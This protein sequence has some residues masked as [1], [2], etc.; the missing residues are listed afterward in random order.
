MK[1]LWD[2]EFEVVNEE[3]TEIYR[4]LDEGYENILILF[5]ALSDGEEMSNRNHMVSLDPVSEDNFLDPRCIISITE[6]STYVI[7]Y[8][9]GGLTFSRSFRPSVIYDEGA[10]H[11]EVKKT[12]ATN[13]FLLTNSVETIPNHMECKTQVVTNNMIYLLFYD[14]QIAPYIQDLV[15][16]PEDDFPAI[17]LGLVIKNK[18]ITI[19]KI[20]RKHL[21]PKHPKPSVVS[22]PTLFD[23]EDDAEGSRGAST[24]SRRKLTAPKSVKLTQQTSAEFKVLYENGEVDFSDDGLKTKIS[25]GIKKINDDGLKSMHAQ[26]LPE[27][28]FYEL[29]DGS[30]KTL[31]DNNLEQY[32]LSWCTDEAA[33]RYE[34]F[35]TVRKEGDMSET[36]ERLFTTG[37]MIDFPIAVL[38]GGKHKYT[39]HKYSD[40]Q[41]SDPYVDKEFSAK[42]AVLSILYLVK[43][44]DKLSRTSGA[45]MSVVSPKHVRFDHKQ[46]PVI[47]EY[48]STEKRTIYMTRG[49][50]KKDVYN[51]HVTPTQYI[52]NNS[53][54]P[55]KSMPFN[56]VSTNIR[57]SFLRDE[58]VPDAI[59]QPVTEKSIFAL[60]GKLVKDNKLDNAVEDHNALS[61]PY[62]SV[63][64]YSAIE[65]IFWL[66]IKKFTES[67]RMYCSATDE[68]D[69]D[70]H[71]YLNILQ[72]Y[73]HLLEADKMCFFPTEVE[74]LIL[75]VLV[76]WRQYFIAQLSNDQTDVVETCLL[77]TVVDLLATA[78]LSKDAFKLYDKLCP[79][80]F[81]EDDIYTLENGNEASMDRLRLGNVS[82][83]KVEQILHLSRSLEVPEDP[84]Q[85]LRLNLPE[86]VDKRVLIKQTQ[87]KNMETSK[88][89]PARVHV[90]AGKSVATY[91][92]CESLIR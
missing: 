20:D 14:K 57:T 52:P 91:A 43:S 85:D 28:V 84:Q 41:L 10:T 45:S 69:E 29:Y 35:L 39:L 53:L 42:D 56:T 59:L 64:M 89:K 63:E 49:V 5:K 79:Q 71:G 19:P 23:D 31:I 78:Y 65:S 12:Q 72:R 25:N 83:F 47:T 81:M 61:T 7:I 40:V 15:G 6:I 30:F 73:E 11:Y 76:I 37:A 2:V 87:L 33:L 82:L 62:V 54:V 75:S 60:V 58:P 44:W 80:R 16:M 1:S 68:G 13:I 66:I 67:N 86:A 90:Y 92:H 48:T 18:N 26:D 70:I 55:F 88:K 24:R 4:C 3:N 74:S 27:S 21:R 51:L 9:T 46:R 36:D 22:L 38:S 17:N 50:V 77:G 32:Q 34:T 8:D